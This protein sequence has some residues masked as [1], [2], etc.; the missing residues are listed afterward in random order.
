MATAGSMRSEQMDKH[1]GRSMI[2]EGT[3]RYAL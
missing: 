2:T 3:T 1:A